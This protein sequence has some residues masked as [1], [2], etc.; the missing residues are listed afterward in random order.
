MLALGIAIALT[1]GFVI[2]IALICA[3]P[4]GFETDE[5]FFYG[6]DPRFQGP[7][8]PR[9]STRNP[10]HPIPGGHLERGSGIPCGPRSLCVAPFH[11]EPVATERREHLRDR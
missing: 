10:R 9:Q 3:A 1:V 11:A 2:L 6:P 4:E 7:L 5:G 8:D